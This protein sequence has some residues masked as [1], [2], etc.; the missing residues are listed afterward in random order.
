MMRQ[1]AGGFAQYEKAHV[2]AKLCAR[3][4]KRKASGKCEAESRMLRRIPKRWRGEAAL[5]HANKSG[6]P[7]AASSVKS[8]VDGK[9]PIA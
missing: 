8:M 1:I 2:V 6:L 5:G 7:F 3:E 9:M 4:R